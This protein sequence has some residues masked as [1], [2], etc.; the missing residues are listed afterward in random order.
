L[1]FYHGKK[2][3][4]FFHFLQGRQ[5]FSPSEL[6]ANR[7]FTRMVITPSLNPP[8]PTPHITNVGKWGKLLEWKWVNFDFESFTL[9]RV[10]ALL[11]TFT[12]MK[13]TCMW[14]EKL[15]SIPRCTKQHGQFTESYSQELNR[16]F[17]RVHFGSTVS[18]NPDTNWGIVPLF[19]EKWDSILLS[20]VLE[21]LNQI[22]SE[23][24]ELDY[25]H[26][27]ILP[28]FLD[29]IWYHEKLL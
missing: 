29:C 2:F 9:H 12:Q 14:I 20:E 1:R 24:A 8:S 21:V 19:K 26:K 17:C 5:F 3:R 10:N 4:H 7:I 27:I 23:L 16:S 25:I 6:F 18:K 28:T 15:S 11:R 13:H 22:K